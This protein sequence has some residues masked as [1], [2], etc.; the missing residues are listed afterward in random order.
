MDS[1]TGQHPALDSVEIWAT[2]K[3][4]SAGDWSGPSLASQITKERLQGLLRVF[5]RGKL[6]NMVK[7]AR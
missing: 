7:V 1:S 3:L 6:D 5:Q 4:A 2:T